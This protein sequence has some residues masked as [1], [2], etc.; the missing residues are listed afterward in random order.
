MDPLQQPPRGRLPV[1]LGSVCPRPLA[2]LEPP[3]PAV[4]TDTVS[5]LAAVTTWVA[6]DSLAVS[7]GNRCGAAPFTTTMTRTWVN[8][9]AKTATTTPGMSC[10]P[11]TRLNYGGA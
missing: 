3:T 8:R 9:S 10:S 2:A 4:T 6:A 5:T 11:G 7:T 1:A